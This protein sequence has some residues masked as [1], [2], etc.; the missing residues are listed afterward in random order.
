MP[1]SFFLGT[2]CN[3]V[4][5]YLEKWCS[6]NIVVC[7]PFIYNSNNRTLLRSQNYTLQPAIHITRCVPPYLFPRITSGITSTKGRQPS[8]TTT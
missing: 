1:Y 7:R 5:G 3:H 4:K 8:K 6:G 2:L